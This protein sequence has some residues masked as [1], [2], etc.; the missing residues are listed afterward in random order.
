MDGLPS[1]PPRMQKKS[2]GV[3]ATAALGFLSQHEL[4]KSFD[5]GFDAAIP[6]LSSVDAEEFDQSSEGSSSDWEASSRQFRSMPVDMRRDHAISPLMVRSSSDPLL[7]MDNPPPRVSRSLPSRLTDAVGSIKSL[8]SSHSSRRAAPPSSPAPLQSTRN[9]VDI[10]TA[11]VSPTSPSRSPLNSTRR[12]STRRKSSQDVRRASS[13]DVSSLSRAPGF[14][15]LSGQAQAFGTFGRSSTVAT[16]C[17]GMRMCH[18][19]TMPASM[20]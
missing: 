2:P 14:A 3:T 13:D 16:G 18:S 15:P 12:A 19:F 1:L 11:P 5:A 17:Y 9:S 6:R 7:E 20:R 8:I 4:R 10:V